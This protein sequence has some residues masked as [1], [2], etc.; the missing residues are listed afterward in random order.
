MYLLQSLQVFLT[1]SFSATATFNAKNADVYE[2]AVSAWCLGLGY[3]GI[4]EK[5][6]EPTI[7]GYILGV[8]WDNGQ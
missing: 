8:Y 1:L 7:I 2:K 5:Q 3:I 6:M 4:M